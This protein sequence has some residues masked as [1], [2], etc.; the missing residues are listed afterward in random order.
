MR[1]HDFDHFAAAMAAAWAFFI[2]D[3]TEDAIGWGF[4]VLGARYT[5]AEVL[6]GLRAHTADPVRGRWP[7][8]PADIVHQIDGD[9]PTQDQIIAAARLGHTRLARACANHIGE[10]DL[11]TGDPMYLR[12]R[13]AECQQ[14]LPTWQTELRRQGDHPRLTVDG[15][16][17]PRALTAE[18]PRAE[19]QGCGDAANARHDIGVQ[20]SQHD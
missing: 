12:Q 11:H 8:T 4:E 20:V 5:L 13:A 14:M 3:L 17:P 10:H 9:P 16:G 19:T 18:A 7:P 2:Q 1:N 15:A 6:E